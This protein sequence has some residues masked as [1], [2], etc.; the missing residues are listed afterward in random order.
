M[1]SPYI[2]A[3]QLDIAWSTGYRAGQAMK[4]RDQGRYDSEVRWFA[5]WAAAA[6]PSDKIRLEDARRVGYAAGN[7]PPPVEHFK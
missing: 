1:K 6:G 2:P 7:P 3:T 4:A 5:D